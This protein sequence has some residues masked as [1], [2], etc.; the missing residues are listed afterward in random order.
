MGTDEGTGAGPAVLNG[1]GPDA[2]L[3]GV[4]VV[5][6]AGLGAASFAVS[7]LGYFG[8]EII[9]IDRPPARQQKGQHHTIAPVRDRRSIRIDLRTDRGASIA[10]ALAGRADIVVEGF[11][12]GVAERLG[13]GPDECMQRNSRLVYARSTGWGQDGPLASS[14][15]HD[16]NYLAISGALY[17]FGPPDGPPA[18]PLNL[19]ADYAAGGT[20]LAFGLLVALHRARATGRGEVIDAAMLDAVTMAMTRL[21]ARLSTGEWSESRGSNQDDGAAPFYNVY[22]TSDG[23]FLAVGAVEPQFFGQLLECLGLNSA[24]LPAQFDRARWPEVKEV[25]AARISMLTREEWVKRAKDYDACISPVLA[26]S[27]AIEH[28]HA[29]S[30]EAF[31]KAGGGIVPRPAPRFQSFQPSVSDPCLPGDSS[32]EILG[33]LGL[34]S[35]EADELFQLGVVS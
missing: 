13:V 31:I 5:E 33:E 19:L 9:R 12:P 21:Y 2:P 10:V 32:R 14:A 16:L 7:M 3:A 34:A 26:P 18:W 29:R 23:K 1:A 22:R 24:E 4:K 8:A 28:P 6:I 20:T 30:R 27:E 15:G 11:R 35:E 25:F 17:S